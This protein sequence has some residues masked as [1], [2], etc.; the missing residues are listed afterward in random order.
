VVLTIL[1]TLISKPDVQENVK[2]V[3]KQLEKGEEKL[4]A[5]DVVLKPDQVF[6]FL[7]KHINHWSMLIV[8]GHE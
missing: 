8:L 1:Q 5:V 6:S 3:Q 2:Q 7:E 4:T